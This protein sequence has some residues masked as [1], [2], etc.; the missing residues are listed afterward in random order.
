MAAEPTTMVH[1]STRIMQMNFG[2]QPELIGGLTINSCTVS[3]TVLNS[4]TGSI[5]IG[6]ISIL[7]PIVYVFLSGGNANNTYLVTFT[8]TLSN[9][10]PLVLEGVCNVVSQNPNA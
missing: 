8:A 6:T 7:G 4:G 1:G 9:N 10:N 2:L 3:Q 5:V